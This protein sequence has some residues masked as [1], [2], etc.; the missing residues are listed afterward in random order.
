[1]VATPVFEELHGVAVGVPVPVKVVVE[2]SQIVKVP[3]I[4]GCASTVNVIVLLHPLVVV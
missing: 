3:P 2:P 1:M 4:V